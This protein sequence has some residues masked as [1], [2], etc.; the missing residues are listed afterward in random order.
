LEYEE[1]DEEEEFIS[2]SVCEEFIRHFLKGTLKTLN[3]IGY[4]NTFI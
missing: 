1:N 2:I 4:L 3:D